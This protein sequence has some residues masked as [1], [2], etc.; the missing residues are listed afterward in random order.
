MKKII[1]SI[2]GLII[3]AIFFFVRFEN[4]ENTTKSLTT[5][6]AIEKNISTDT[7]KTSIKKNKYNKVK[8]RLEY[9]KIKKEENISKT[10][11]QSFKVDNNFS[12]TAIVKT[13]DKKSVLKK[14]KVIKL[15]K[16]IFLDMQKKMLTEMQKIP[17]CLENA[18]NKKEALQC[19][20]KL[21]ELNTEFELSIGIVREQNTTNL[22]KDFKWN[23]TTK[24][25]MIKELDK[26][27]E[28]MQNLFDCLQ[29]SDTQKEQDKCFKGNFNI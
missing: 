1:L 2:I 8:N 13:F 20:R 6:K 29:A 15:Q 24:E 21:R 5:N 17:D 12:N 23:E 22:N 11:Y 16:K 25:N 10:R 7:E 28:N 3:V 14:E 26:G 9:S 27:I 19:S 18:Q 4:N